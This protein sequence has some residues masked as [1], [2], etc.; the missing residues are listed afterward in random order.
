M[1]KLQTE[2]LL[3]IPIPGTDLYPGQQETIANIFR[4]LYYNVLWK[5][6]AICQ[7]C[8]PWNS[9]R[10]IIEMGT[11]QVTHTPFLQTFQI[12]P[13][14]RHEAL[15]EDQIQHMGTF[16]PSKQGKQWG[17]NE[18]QAQHHLSVLAKR[19]KCQPASSLVHGWFCD[20]WSAISTGFEKDTKSYWGRYK[21]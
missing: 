4:V 15:D 7:R 12:L 1:F 14:T 11:R 3:L 9:C 20:S 18:H 19:A 2:G 8:V 6:A 21:P 17:K 13:Q 5:S 16:L 10:W